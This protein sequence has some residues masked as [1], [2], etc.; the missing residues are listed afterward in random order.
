LV[1]SN[2]RKDGFEA[3][4]IAAE[5]KRL[6]NPEPAKAHYKYS[7]RTGQVLPVI[8]ASLRKSRS[9]GGRTLSPAAQ[10]VIEHIREATKL[11]AKLT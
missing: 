4:T 8:T 11:L 2:L 7:R 6:E 9:D 10:L 5:L 3:S 1:V